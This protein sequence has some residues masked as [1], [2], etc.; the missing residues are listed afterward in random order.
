[1]TTTETG[2][3]VKNDTEYHVASFVAH[4]MKANLEHVQQAIE[5]LEGAELHATS[6][7]G[8]IIFTIEATSQHDIGQR[9]DQL[10]YHAGLLSLSPVYHQFIPTTNQA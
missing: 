7:E 5:T 9:I 2:S 8:K 4:A 1:M 3:I 10:K 6:P